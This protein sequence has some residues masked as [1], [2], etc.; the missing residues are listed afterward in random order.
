MSIKQNLVGAKI[1]D[2]MKSYPNLIAYI[3]AMGEFMDDTR[4]YIDH[5]K[6]H[7]DYKNGTDF[8]IANTLRSEGIELP[9]NSENI[10][11]T[12]LRDL[13]HNFVRKG[14]IDSISWVLNIL[15]ID[16]QLDQIWLP[17]PDDLY[18]GMYRDFFTGN[19]TRY[20]VSEESHKDFLYGE[21]FILNE[22]TYFKGSSYDWL[23]LTPA[24]RQAFVSGGGANIGFVTGTQEEYQYYG[25]PIMGEG[26]NT[27]QSES[28]RVC[29]T[30][31]FLLRISYPATPSELTS[32]LIET[33]TLTKNRPIN[34][35][36]IV[37][38]V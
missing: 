1:P 20:N 26:Y 14:T 12:I 35:R 3:E 19:V 16:Y 2:F 17:N 28:N 29:S 4:G 21:S 27:I 38:V 34:S 31:H 33:L 10:P 25:I 36:I 24:E 11:R 15:N 6:N 7:A 5:F 18:I 8:N 32:F 37:E 30:P 23:K 9:A 13:V 22:Q